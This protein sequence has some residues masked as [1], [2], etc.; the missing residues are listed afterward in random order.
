MWIGP[1]GMRQARP[2][3][4]RTVNAAADWLRDRTEGLGRRAVAVMPAL[5]SG[6]SAAVFWGRQQVAVYS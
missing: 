2:D 5:T 4:R 3:S 1:L 6:C